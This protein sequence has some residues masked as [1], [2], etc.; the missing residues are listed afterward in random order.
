MIFLLEKVSDNEASDSEHEVET[1]TSSQNT[2]E[3]KEE[4]LSLEDGALP[5]EI[6]CKHLSSPNPEQIR[7]LLTKG[8]AFTCQDCL[9][10][11]STKKKDK[12]AKPSK[13]SSKKV[14]N[15]PRPL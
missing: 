10:G 2:E 3:S 15:Y 6:N 13:G 1:P 9:A 5:I 12:K 8:T 7:K 14:P 4:E 11:Q